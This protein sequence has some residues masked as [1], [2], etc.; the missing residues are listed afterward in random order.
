MRDGFLGMPVWLVVVLAVLVIVVRG[1]VYYWIGRGTGPRVY[2]SRLGRRVGADRLRRVEGVV[3]RRGVL[4]VVGAHWVAGLRHAIPVCAGVARMPFGRYT[5]ATVVGA[6]LWTPPW[7]VGGYAVVWGWL[8]VFGRSPLAVAGLAAAVVAALALVLVLRR[9]R[10]RA[11]V[12][13]GS[14]SPERG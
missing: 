13:A 2:A 1:Q 8:R 4:A 9:R 3:A 11:P 5:F 7:I 6:A 12:Q 14:A 10:T